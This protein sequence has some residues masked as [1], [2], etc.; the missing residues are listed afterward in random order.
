MNLSRVIYLRE[1]PS[2]ALLKDIQQFRLDG[3]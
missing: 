3:K 1:M 2:T